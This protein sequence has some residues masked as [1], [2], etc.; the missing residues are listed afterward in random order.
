M[1]AVSGIVVGA[2]AAGTAD[3]PGLES[4][5]AALKPG[6]DV[7]G[8][9]A[10][11]MD[12]Q[13]RYR[14]VNTA[15]EIQTGRPASDFLARTPD[16]VFVLKPQDDRRSNM[17]RAL[18]GEIEVFN[19]RNLEGPQAGRWVRAHYFPLREAEGAVVGVLV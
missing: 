18:A 2:A 13:M 1:S 3:R 5:I 9:P 12:T 14:Y 7:L 19:R 8:L 16:E 6:L 11:V 10:C 4:R 15:Y 17:R